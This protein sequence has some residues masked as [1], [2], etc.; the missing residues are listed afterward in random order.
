MTGKIT[1][2]YTFWCG[3][4]DCCRWDQFSEG[5][6][7]SSAIKV[8][9]R[10]GWKRTRSEGWICPDCADEHEPAKIDEDCMAGKD[11]T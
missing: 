5:K 4:G 6:K 7:V 1:T 2:E 9:R 11:V 3:H 8:A 10:Q